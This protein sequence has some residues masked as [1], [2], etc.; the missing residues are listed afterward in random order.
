MSALDLLLLAAGHAVVPQV[1]EAE[2][3]SRSISDVAF[4][5]L[6]TNRWRLVVD[7]TTHGQAQKPVNRPHPLAVTLG[8]VIVHRHNVNAASRESV[9]KHRQR[10]DEC[11]ALA[12]GHFRDLAQ[13]QPRAAQQLHIKRNHVP[14]ELVTAHFDLLADHAAAGVFHHGKGFRENLVERRR[15]LRRFLNGGQAGLPRGGFFAQR[16]GRQR[17]Q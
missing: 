5:L 1:I 7:D 11:L 10:G 12:G 16:L 8:E 13:M 2:F 14:R 17:L 15:Q 9:E 4:V 3:R 6:A